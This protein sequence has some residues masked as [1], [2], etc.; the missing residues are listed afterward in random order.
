MYLFNVTR[1]GGQ[2]KGE[3]V[4]TLGELEKWLAD[5]KDVR[6]YYLGAVALGFIAITFIAL[7]FVTTG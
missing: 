5:E 7:R 4:C 6:K 1:Y 3:R 2:G